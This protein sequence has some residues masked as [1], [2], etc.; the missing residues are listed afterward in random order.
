MPRPVRLSVAACAVL[1]A[2]LGGCATDLES[3]GSQRLTAD[4]GNL[5]TGEPALYPTNNARS[6]NGEPMDYRTPR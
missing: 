5:G 4:L 1:S 3:R 6:W 2:L